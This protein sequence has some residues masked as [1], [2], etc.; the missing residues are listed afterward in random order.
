M[1]YFTLRK[2]AWK[3]RRAYIENPCAKTAKAQ[4]RADA[5]LR[6]RIDRLN[7]GTAVVLLEGVA[8]VTDEEKAEVNEAMGR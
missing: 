8:V 6:E 3:A 7:V 5:A 4:R 1:L 2:R